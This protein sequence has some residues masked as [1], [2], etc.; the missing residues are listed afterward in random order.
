[1]S[2]SLALHLSRVPRKRFLSLRAQLHERNKK[3]T[4]RPLRRKERGRH[5]T[6]PCPFMKRAR[7]RENER[8]R[9]AAILVSLSLVPLSV[10]LCLFFF[11]SLRSALLLLLS[12]RFL[13]GRRR[14][15]SC[16]QR[17]EE[18]GK[19]DRTSHLDISLCLC[20]FRRLFSTSLPY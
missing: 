3:R 2:V 1:M 20:H 17:E 9:G 7:E 15:R 5:L 10:S 6:E 14:R 13:P 11:S 8:T 19:K 12:L 18:E 4:C 16:L